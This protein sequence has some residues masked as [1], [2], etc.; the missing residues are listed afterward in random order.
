[1]SPKRYVV[2]S[3]VPG[4][5]KSTLAHQLSS[6]LGLCVIDKDDILD[7]LFDSK[8]IGD[9]EALRAKG[10]LLVSFWHQHGMPLDS[11]TSTEWLQSLSHHV[12]HVHCACE[13]SIAA[14]RF[15]QRNR[16]PGHL[17]SQRVY[18]QILAWIVALGELDIGPR[19]KVDTSDQVSVS[20]VIEE[21]EAAFASCSG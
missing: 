18:S 13:P 4:S 19:I 21:I 16:H 8:G 17:D 5:G 12:V 10:A 15:A 3:G 6:A 20:T 14:P 7:G 9:A 1:M 2:F 11:G